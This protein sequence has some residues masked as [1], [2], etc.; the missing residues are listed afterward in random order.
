MQRKDTKM[1]NKIL[2]V[3]ERYQIAHPDLPT[4][5]A[6]IE[7]A[8]TAR[9]ADDAALVIVCNK[10]VHA[11]DESRLPAG[12]VFYASQGNLAMESAEALGLSV[13]AALLEAARALKERDWRRVYIVPSGLPVLAI[14]LASL[15]Y[16]VKVFPAVVLQYDR[17]SGDYWSLAF[18]VRK[19]ASQA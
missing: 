8:V 7:A 2:S 5:A 15:V 18:E 19:L 11:I 3:L 12:R 4:L 16:Q 6:E 1:R 9:E 17:E 10:G 14:A 13:E